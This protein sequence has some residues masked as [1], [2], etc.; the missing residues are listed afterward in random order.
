MKNSIAYQLLRRS[1]KLGRVVNPSF[2]NFHVGEFEKV[3]NKKA[4]TELLASMELNTKFIVSLK[5]M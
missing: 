1:E 5:C 2:R 3:V 4:A